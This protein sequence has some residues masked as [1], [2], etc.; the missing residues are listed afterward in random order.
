MYTPP[1]SLT[2]NNTMNDVPQAYLDLANA[3][4]LKAVVDYRLTNDPRE[5]ESLECFFRSDWF[6]MLTLDPE[7]VS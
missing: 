4:V 5:L 7:Y 2:E 1:H 3:V 6:S